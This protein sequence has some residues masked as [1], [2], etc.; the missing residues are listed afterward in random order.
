MSEFADSNISLVDGIFIKLMH[1]RKKG[2]IAQTH[3][4]SFDHQTILSCGRLRVTVGDDV[5]EYQAPT[6]IVIQKGAPHRL[7]A[8]EDNTIATCVHQIHDDVPIVEGIPN[9]E[10]KK[11]T[12]CL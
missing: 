11:E 5:Q 10:L 8:L 7:E 9:D 1:F 12:L 6:V 2:W 4:H 3:V